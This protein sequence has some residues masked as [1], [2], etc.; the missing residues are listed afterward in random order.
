MSIEEGTS[1]MANLGYDLGYEG[2]RVEEI[3]VKTITLIG[4]QD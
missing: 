2:L 1:P 3:V 4:G